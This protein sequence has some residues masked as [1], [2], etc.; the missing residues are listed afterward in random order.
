VVRWIFTRY[1][2]GHSPRAIAHEL[3]ARGI[4][5]A[6]GGPWAVSALIG[7]KGK[8][9]GLLHNELYTGRVLWNRRQWLKDPDTGARRYVERP[10]TEWQEREDPALRIVPDELWR[11][12]QARGRAPA[13]RGTREGRGA[14]PRTL[15]GGL[16]RC[17]LCG[18]PV[19]AVDARMYG[20]HA[21]KDRGPTE[22]AGVSVRRVDL[23][24]RL[25]AEVRAELL[26][27]AAIAELHTTVRRLAGA[28]T[29]QQTTDTDTPAKRLQ[30]LQGE[31]GRLVDAVATVGLSD[32]LRARLAAAEAEQAALQHQLR[33]AP[34]AP[35]DAAQLASEAISRWRGK[36]MDLQAALDSQK[37]DPAERDR[38]RQ[39][40]ADLLG[41]VTVGRD[42]STG[43]AW[44][45]LEEPAER[46]LIAA[47]GGA[48]L[49]VVAGGGNFSRRRVSLGR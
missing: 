33:R 28:I 24:R 43:E 35:P 48:L 47:A 4:K 39:I 12:V 38:T 18:G 46:L 31:I 17:S 23:E 16:L 27:P 21:H 41:E 37:A 2:D 26:S 10:R 22:C 15:F 44:A 3:N 7:P 45:D 14:V 6:R 30:A 13:P 1:A 5:S 29:R 40:L 36:V 32:A 34:P 11:R 42:A 49:G 8:G 25:L 20:C 9:L 19:V